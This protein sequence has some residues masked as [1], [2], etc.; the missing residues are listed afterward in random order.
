MITKDEINKRIAELDMVPPVVSQVLN[1]IST[2]D[3]NVN[4]A[5]GVISYDPSLTANILKIVNSPYMGLVDKVN[6]ISEAIVIIGSKT[7]FNLVILTAAEMI[8]SEDMIE[9][10]DVDGATLWKASVFGATAAYNLCE[11]KKKANSNLAFTAGLLRD[12]GKIVLGKLVGSQGADIIK[13]AREKNIGFVAAERQML[14]VD[15]SELSSM[16]LSYWKFPEAM[17]SAVKYHHSPHLYPA[18][19]QYA[20]YVYAAHIADALCLKSGIGLG[21]DGMAYTI[22]APALEHFSLKGNDIEELLLATL[23]DF[24]NIEKEMDA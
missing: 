21:A 15:H 6:S 14:G 12:T 10:Y 17:I 8:S 7:L 16:I 24:R 3:F 20:D 4:E 1:I 2:P 5:A 19:G 11:K 13:A 22:Y 9:G 18:D 23:N